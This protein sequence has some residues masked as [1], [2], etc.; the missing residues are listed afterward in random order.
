[1][2][3]LTPLGLLPSQQPDLLLLKL[4]A[5]AAADADLGQRGRQQ[6]S[7]SSSGVSSSVAAVF[8][9]HC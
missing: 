9:L 2:H 6:S 8:L 1:V 4:L 3:Q 5:D 7:S